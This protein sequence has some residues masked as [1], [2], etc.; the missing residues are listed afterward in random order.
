[1][2][3]FS[4]LYSS[5]ASFAKWTGLTDPHGFEHNFYFTGYADKKIKVSI[6]PRFQEVYDDYQSYVGKFIDKHL[7][8]HMAQKIKFGYH[9][10]VASLPFMITNLKKGDLPDHPV[11]HDQHYT[12]ARKA[13]ADAFRPP[14]LVRPVH[15]ADLRY[16]KWNWHPNVEEPY[17]SDPK[18]QQYVE[19][20]YALGLIDDARLSFGNLK[21]FVFMDTRH[22]LHLIKNGSIT[23]NN[24]L[25]PIM[26]IHVKPALTE[27]TETKIRVI[28]GVSKR[29]I[30]AQAM[31]FWPL[32]RYYIEEHTSPLLWGNETFTGG[33]LKIHNLISVPRL[34]S[35]TYL[36]V[37]WS[38]FDLRSL[39]T[40]QR[41]IFDDWRTYFD[42]TAYIPTRTYP[43]SKTDPI[44]MERLWNW[45]RDACFKMPFV[46]PDRTTY[47]RLFRSIPSGLFVTQFLDSHYNLIMI[48]TI[49]SAMGFDITN[50]MIL[51]QGDDSLIH[52]KF[53]LPADQHDAFKAEFERL[54]KYYFDHIAR[55]E[56]TH[57]T[58]SPNEVEVLGYT[59]NNGYPS[60]DMTKLVAQLYHPRN[61]DK[62]SWKS[63]LMAKVCGFAYASCYQDSQ[64]IDLLRSIY[65][66]LASKGFKPK[67]GR[68]MRDIILFG[69]SEFEVPTDHFPTL[70][71]VTKYF[72]RP[73]VRTQR[74]ADSYF[75]SWHFNDVF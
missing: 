2:K 59:N 16:Y 37:D 48:Y 17:Y 49:L 60:R 47:A 15:F 32:F 74:D 38:G 20:C 1:M 51:V 36:T 71:D 22:Y 14:R 58:N 40:I 13:A 6:N 19:H 28:Y 68:V 64:V 50:L 25:W 35:Q 46:L 23:D 3:I 34:Y 26:K 44:R 42:F 73:Y 53:F 18:L 61:V 75:P 45:Q 43:D 11:P 54:A 63:L 39:F 69:E 27:P 8:G 21:D 66:N 56:K 31:F 29:H 33:M 30:L 72:R 12:A 70:N 62:T 55:P 5:F 65:N 10:P 24:Q 9:H 41:E 52:L 57:V 7:P 67:S 4:T